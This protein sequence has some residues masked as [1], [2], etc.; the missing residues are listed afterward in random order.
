MLLIQ[1][2]KKIMLYI[3]KKEKRKEKV[4]EGTMEKKNNPL[5]TI[6]FL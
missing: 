2:K 4:S 3:K 5:Q 6:N 1:K